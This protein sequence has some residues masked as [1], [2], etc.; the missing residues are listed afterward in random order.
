MVLVAFQLMM[1]FA[2]VFF[3]PHLATIFKVIVYTTIFVFLYQGLSLIN[4]N[5][6]DIPLTTRQKRSF[7]W[8]YIVNVLLIAYLFAVVVST[9]TILYIIFD[10]EGRSIVS[11]VTLFY[12]LLPFLLASVIF[13]LH[14]VFLG[15][16]FRLRRTIHQNTIKGWYNQFEENKPEQ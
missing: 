2:E 6:P 13:L 4:Y 12:L 14:L 10:R 5:Y 8:L 3:T 1:S 16:M 7:N 9:R 11:G 15:G